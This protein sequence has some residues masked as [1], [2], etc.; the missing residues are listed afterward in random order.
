MKSLYLAL[1]LTFCAAVMF[2]QTTVPR[3][4][5][6]EVFSSS[7]CGPCKPSNDHLS[8]IFE[9]RKGEIAVVKYQMRWPGL[10]DPYYTA[11]GNNRR[12][13]Y[14]I[15]SIPDFF[16]NAMQQSYA[17]FTASSIDE[18]LEQEAEMQMELRYMVNSETQTVSIKARIEALNDFTAGGHRL[19]I[20]I[21]EEVAYNNV[22]SNGETEFHN[23]FKKMMPGPYGEIIIG[24]ISAGQVFELDTTYVFQGSYRLPADAD[25]EI[26][27]AT[28]HSVEDFDNLHVIMFMQSLGSDKAIYQAAVG[29]HAVSEKDFERA[30]G[31]DPEPPLSI[32]EFNA[33]KEMVVYP[34]PAED[35]VTIERTG[36]SPILA[37][38]LMDMTGKVIQ[39]TADL[40]GT[41]TYLHVGELPS[42]IYLLKVVTEEGAHVERLSVQH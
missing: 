22:K 30:W 33:G 10:G 1:G 34:N 13:V 15:N 42:G 16:R 36:T 29:E 14:S 23:V 7:T 20:P 41:R 11:E 35:I 8:P 17:S 37:V 24:E 2:A 25:D 21:V 18:D 3:V 39:P 9:E 6:Y 31:T 28:E 5:L 12:N 27:H 26:D 32:A 40:A 4:P 38:S 19:M